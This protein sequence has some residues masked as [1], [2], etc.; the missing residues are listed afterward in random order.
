MKEREDG[1]ATGL[2]Q[3]ARERK[4][5][6]AAP[7]EANEPKRQTEKETRRRRR[8]SSR[9]ALE[10]RSGG[11]SV[12]GRIGVEGGTSTQ[13]GPGILAVENNSKVLIQVGKNLVASLA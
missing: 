11:E 12:E 2:Q 8:K 3:L 6:R 7:S 10:A 1:P 13:D 4:L 5:P 9:R